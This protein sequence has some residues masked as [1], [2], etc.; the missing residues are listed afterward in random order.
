MIAPPVDLSRSLQALRDAAGQRSIDEDGAAFGIA[1]AVDIYQVGDMWA[2]A[3]QGQ[4]PAKEMHRRLNL[5]SRRLHEAVILAEELM[6]DDARDA[7]TGDIDGAYNVSA[8]AEI[9]AE[10]RAAG[11]P[12][13]TGAD[14]FMRDL[15]NVLALDAVAERLDSAVAA[16]RD[17]RGRGR[18]PDVAFRAFIKR[19]ASVYTES[20]GLMP[21]E[22]NSRSGD[23]VSP[24][25]RFVEA[26][27]IDCGLPV[28][29]VGIGN[30]VSAVLR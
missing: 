16:V 10:N 21:A 7:V 11:E 26:V 2:D 14:V 4:A 13:V 28:G 29:T 9:D 19:L 25:S 17:H 27:V 24:F 8:K 20:T 1:E 12:V 6:A 15:K 22:G 5:L 30:R 23:K 3:R 18:R